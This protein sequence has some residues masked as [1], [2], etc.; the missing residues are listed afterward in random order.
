MSQVNS[1]FPSGTGLDPTIGGFFLY[2]L[3]GLGKYYSVV[4]LIRAQASLSTAELSDAKPLGV[5]RTPS[6]K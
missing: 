3:K 4:A 6:A 5:T 2:I 1:P